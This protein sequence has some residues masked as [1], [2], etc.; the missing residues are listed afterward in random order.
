M[1]IGEGR[2]GHADEEQPYKPMSLH[3]FRRR[4]RGPLRNANAEVKESTARLDRLAVWITTDVGTMGFFLII[5]LWTA[6]WL[7]WN[8]FVPPAPQ[9]DAPMG[10]AF[11]LFLSN[12]M[13]ILLMPLIM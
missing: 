3:E 1:D 5:S 13:Q 2:M 6:A 11:G 10:F 8:W 4:H 12:L 9:F 7:G